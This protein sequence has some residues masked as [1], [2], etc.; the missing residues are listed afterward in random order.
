MEPDAAPASKLGCEPETVSMKIS[1]ASDS[2]RVADSAASLSGGWWSILRR[3][4]ASPELAVT[5]YYPYYFQCWKVTAP[6]TL[7]RTAKVLLSTGV[8]GMNRSVGPAT[9][10]PIGEELKVRKAEVISPHTGV[11]EAEQLAREYIEKFVVRRYRPSQT[12]EIVRER[13]KLVY[14]PYY[15]YAREGQPLRKATLVEGFTGDVGRV[16]DVPPVLQSITRQETAN[17]GKEGWD[18]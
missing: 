7:G 2:R 12:P 4:H 8:N 16:K 6:K 10:W 18:K 3:R 17:V 1:V 5:R 11:A 15:V 13:F 14:V 9:E